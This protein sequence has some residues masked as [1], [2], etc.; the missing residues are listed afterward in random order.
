[1]G[2]VHSGQWPVSF[3]S[4]GNTILSHNQPLEAVSSYINSTNSGF[5]TV[6]V[7]QSPQNEAMVTR[8]D[9]QPPFRNSMVSLLKGICAN[10]SATMHRK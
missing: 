6:G 8:E 1:M 10:H 2:G 4:E 5:W 3:S 7:C 9:E